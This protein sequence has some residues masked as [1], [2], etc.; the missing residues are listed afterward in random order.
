MSKKV[1]LGNLGGGPKG[2][3]V[4][5][6]ELVPDAWPKFEGFIRHVAKAGPQH[7][8]AKPHKPPKSKPKSKLTK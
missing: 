6:V 4:S 3:E 2:Q 1:N 7:R 8:P 5:E